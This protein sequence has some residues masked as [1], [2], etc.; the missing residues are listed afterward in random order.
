MEVT[1]KCTA[2]ATPF[3]SNISTPKGKSTYNTHTNIK[4]YR[5]NLPSGQ[6]IENT[7]LAD[8]TFDEN[9]VLSDEVQ[10]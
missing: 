5:L 7:D 8:G 1:Q 6:F 4:T 3:L 9:G 10:F 2:Q